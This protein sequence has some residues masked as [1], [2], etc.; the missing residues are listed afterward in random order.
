MSLLIFVFLYCLFTDCSIWYGTS[1][2]TWIGL[3]LCF[4]IEI[5]PFWSALKN[6]YGFKYIMICEQ[7]LP[8]PWGPPSPGHLLPCA[9]CA[10]LAQEGD[11]PHSPFRRSK[12]LDDTWTADGVGRAPSAACLYV[13]LLP[14]NSPNTYCILILLL[15]RVE[16]LKVLQ[17]KLF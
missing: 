12:C 16:K 11:Q 5:S 14:N 15:G 4:S 13:R 8:R 17:I 1:S 9:L 7:T 3:K 6:S 10:C 2:C